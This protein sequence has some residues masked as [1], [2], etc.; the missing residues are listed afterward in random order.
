[1]TSNYFREYIESISQDILVQIFYFILSDVALQKQVN[2]NDE[3]FHLLCHNKL[4]MF[5]RAYI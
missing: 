5:W 1:M 3:F 2:K 4:G